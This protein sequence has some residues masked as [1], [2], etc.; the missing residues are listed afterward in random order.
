MPHSPDLID[1][2]LKEAGF[3]DDMK[4][5]LTGF[6]QSREKKRAVSRVGAHFDSK[7]RELTTSSRSTSIA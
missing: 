1:S 2:I 3:F 7:M 6:L 5:K 4:S